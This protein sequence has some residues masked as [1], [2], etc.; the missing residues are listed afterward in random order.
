MTNRYL[1][2]ALSC[3]LPTICLGQFPR[4]RDSAGVHIVENSARS[5]A[6]IAFRVSDK[7]SFDV[8]GLKDN[9]ADEL[10]PRGGDL[11]SIT[12]ANG[13]HVVDDEVKLRFFDAT[14]RQFQVSGRRGEGPGE[15]RRIYS[16]CR[17]HGDT[18]VASDGGIGRITIVDKAGA[19]VREIAAGHSAMPY[20]GCFDDGTFV[21]SQSVMGPDRVLR[22]KLIRYNLAGT[23]LGSLGENPSF[24]LGFWL[25]ISPT[26][27]ARGTLLYVADPR[28]REVR[29]FDQSGKLTSIIRTDDPVARTTTAER[30]VMVPTL[31]PVPLDDG[32]KQR[33]KDRFQNVPRPTVWPSFEKIAVDPDGR[34]WIMDWRKVRTDPVAWTAFDPSGRLLGRLTF[35]GTTKPGDPFISRF[36]SGGI[37]VMRQDDD[38][39]THLTTYPLIA[40]RGGRP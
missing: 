37:E 22:D 7:P 23:M 1:L 38:G 34:L 12:L 6:P 10:D 29:I 28:A 35:P 40:M 18:I 27:T 33:Y 25:W 30:A 14:G 11:K 26:Y 21:A 31:C 3:V 5:Q 13:T 39:A 17:T 19:I 16:L 4:I 36:T 9:P 15:F 8:G 2:V 32:C 24:T 20:N